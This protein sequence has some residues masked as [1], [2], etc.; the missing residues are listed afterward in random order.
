VAVNKTSC[1]LHSSKEEIPNIKICSANQFCISHLKYLSTA[2]T[3][4]VARA[5]TTCSKKKE[6]R[7]SNSTSN[8]QSKM[9]LDHPGLHILTKPKKHITPCLVNSFLE[10]GHEIQLEAS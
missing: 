3:R 8:C 4:L 9:D 1:F 2:G 7:F 6:K 10:V 5:D